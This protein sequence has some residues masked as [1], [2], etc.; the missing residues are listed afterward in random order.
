MDFKRD[1]NWRCSAKIILAVSDHLQT[2]FRLT[3]GSF[4][5]SPSSLRVAGGVCVDT[6]Q[7]A[8]AFHSRVDTERSLTGFGLWVG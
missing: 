5:L 4:S 2:Q 1:L 8:L 3:A 6:T 7:T